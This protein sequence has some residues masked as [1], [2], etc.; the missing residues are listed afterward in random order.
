MA[1]NAGL[2]GF[3][4]GH[5][6]LAELQDCVRTVAAGGRYL[7]EA[8]L[9]C[10]ADGFFHDRWTPKELIVLGCL[11]EG[12]S[13]KAIARRLGLSIGTIKCHVAAILGKLKAHSRT[14]AVQLAT[15]RGLVPGAGEMESPAGRGLPGVSLLTAREGFSAAGSLLHPHQVGFGRVVGRRDD[16]HHGVV[17]EHAVVQRRQRDADVVDGTGRRRVEYGHQA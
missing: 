11:A 9:R 15:A 13:N 4:L 17:A 1:L 12:L 3:L 16:A 6:R 7:S 5:C 8:A 14:Q 2:N 10:M